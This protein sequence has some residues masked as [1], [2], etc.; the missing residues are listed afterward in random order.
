MARKYYWLK[1]E[2]GE[3]GQRLLE[4]APKLRDEF[5]AY[6]TDYQT[7]F[8]RGV[9]YDNPVQ[10]NDISNLLSVRGAWQVDTLRYSW[11]EHGEFHSQYKD[12]AVRDRFPTACSIVDWLGDDCPLAT[13]S[14]IEPNSVIG[15]HEDGEHGTGKLLRIHVPL[16]IPKGDVFM[17]IEGHTIDWSDIYGFDGRYTHSVHNL[18]ADRRLIFLID[19]TRSRLGL[20][21]AVVFDLKKRAANWPPFVRGLFPQQQH[22]GS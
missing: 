13:Y 5:L 9:P 17:E 16:L 1:Q 22:Q 7:A 8:S 20:E 4:A 2:L 3:V 10:G 11:E 19:I 12:P 18:T 14:S 21:P 6:H 15:R